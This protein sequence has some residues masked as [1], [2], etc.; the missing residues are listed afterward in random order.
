MSVNT[1]NILTLPETDRVCPTS[2]KCLVTSCKLGGSTFST[3][4]S[5]SCKW[6]RIEK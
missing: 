6:L 5:I 1:N 3:E 2:G 4:I